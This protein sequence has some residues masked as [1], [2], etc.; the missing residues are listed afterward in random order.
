MPTKTDFL[1]SFLDDGSIILTQHP[2]ASILEDFW[3]LV[4]DYKCSTI[5]MLKDM[6][7]ANKTA[8]KYWPDSGLITFGSITVKCVNTER[9][10]LLKTQTFEVNHQDY[11]N[12]DPVTVNHLTFEA[13]LGDD[14]ALPKMVDFIQ[15]TRN[16]TSGP[17]LIHCLNGV[18][19]S[20]VY[21]TAKTQ[22]QCLE[23]EGACDVYLAV[24]K[25][26]RKNVNFMLSQ[27]NYTLC[28]KLL[29]CYLNNQDDYSVIY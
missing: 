8:A 25:L 29:R 9:Q 14:E 23:K 16:V 11:E 7:T 19:V 28:L 27:D 6:S 10:D 24:Q 21:V 4:Y 17:T 18:G 3:R 5:I 1:G 20:A 22:I 15:S 12:E 26:R 13:L 2:L